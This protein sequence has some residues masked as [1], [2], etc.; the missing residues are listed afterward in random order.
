MMKG[1][2][3]TAQCA[4]KGLLLASALMAGGA[5]SAAA[6]NTLGVSEC[7]IRALPGN[8][9]SGGYFVATNSGDQAVDLVAVSTPAFG[10]AMLHQS[11]TQGGT[12][13]MTMV[14]K[15]SVPAHGKLAFTPGDYHLM[16]EQPTQPVQI[17]AKVPMTFM[18]SGGQK[19]AAVCEVKN[20]GA[21]GP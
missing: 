15:V 6:G 18:F 7:W 5:A 11:Q 21:T 3:R 17:G 9:P 16:L 14:D 4:L 8:L 2:R 10:M 1:T 19:I 20:A 13:R 12:S